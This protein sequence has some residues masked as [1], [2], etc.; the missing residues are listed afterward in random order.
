MRLFDIH[1][2]PDP[3][4]VRRLD[5]IELALEHILGKLDDMTAIDWSH[6]EADV[7]GLT[8]LQDSIDALIAKLAGA[9][10]A[11]AATLSNPDDQAK[12][13][14]LAATIEAFAA[15]LGAAVTANTPADTIPQPPANP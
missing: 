2:F 11:T 8:G 10:H 6:I 12:V 3:D 4:T 9:A 5:R 15:H 13:T 14:Q 7:A 1:I